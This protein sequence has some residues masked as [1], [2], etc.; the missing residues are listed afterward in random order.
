MTLEQRFHREAVSGC[1]ELLRKH[2]YNPAYYLQMIRTHG[3]V[4]TAKRLLADTSA[5]SGL[6]RLWELKCLQNEYRSDS[7]RTAILGLVHV[8][9]DPRSTKASARS[10][11][12][13]LTHPN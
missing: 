9:G 3:A 12:P 5:Q 8:R 6:F 1:E 10:S 2:A 7:Y 13:V 4:G 11:L